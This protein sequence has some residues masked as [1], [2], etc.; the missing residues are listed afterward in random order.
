MQGAAYM[1][2]AARGCSRVYELTGCTQEDLLDGLSQQLRLI[3]GEFDAYDVHLVF[4]AVARS[5]D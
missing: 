3:L 4:A 5:A 1:R 2:T